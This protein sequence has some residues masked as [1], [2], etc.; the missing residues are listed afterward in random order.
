MDPDKRATA[1]EC[2]QHPWLNMSPS[3]RVSAPRPRLPKKEKTDEMKIGYDI[4]S[5]YSKNKGIYLAEAKY[6]SDDNENDGDEDNLDDD[7]DDEDEEDEEE[8]EEDNNDEEDF[9]SRK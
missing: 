3:D 1:E 4:N 8:E 6:E 7:V 9:K 5:N 2:L